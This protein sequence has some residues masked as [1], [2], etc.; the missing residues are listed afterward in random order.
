MSGETSPGLG[1]ER[2]CELLAA[3]DVDGL[4]ALAERCLDDGADVTVLAGPDVG[5]VAL[6]VREPIVGERFFVGDALVTRAEVAL[7][8]ARGWSMRMGSDRVATLAAAVLDAEVEARR[9][10][11]AEV[12][13][14]CLAT[15]Q[16]LAAAD[17]AEW[18]D[19]A[20]T[21]VQF[22]ELD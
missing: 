14:L 10:R 13:D 5:T 6:Q 18:A 9:P 15:E 3:A 21:E 11:A 12:V 19:L 8:G 2:R 7:D 17:H 22:E 4:V 1:R 20:P 16:A